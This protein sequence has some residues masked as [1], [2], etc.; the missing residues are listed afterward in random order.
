MF[1]RVTG[2]FGDPSANGCTRTIQRAA[3]GFGFPPEAAADSVEWCRE[4]FVVGKWEVLLGPEG[5]PL[6]LAA[7]QL[8]RSPVINAPA[9]MPVACGGVGMPPL[10][11][12]IDPS[13]ID[14]VWIQTPGGGTSIAVFDSEFRLLLGDPPRVVASN[15]VVLLDGEVLDPDRGKAGLAICPGGEVIDFRMLNPNAPA[16]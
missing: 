8:H 11:F 2:Q 13:K 16:P 4:Q 12:R 1:L 15:G 6:D 3:P 14:P 10:T 7:P 9:G 5:R